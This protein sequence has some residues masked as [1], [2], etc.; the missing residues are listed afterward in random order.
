MKQTK[1]ELAWWLVA[2][3]AL[4]GGAARAQITPL[5][6][7]A[8][9]VVPQQPHT[10]IDATVDTIADSNIARTND[11][12]AQL[13]GL[14]KA[15]VRF[16]PSL[17]TDLYRAFGQ[18]YVSL[19]ASGGYDVNVRNS[20]LNS[21]RIAAMVGAGSQ[22]GPCATSGYAGYNR[23]QSDL[24]D[25]IVL[26]QGGRESVRNT[27]TLYWVSGTIACGATYGLRPLAIGGYA[28]GRNS[29]LSRIGGDYRATTY[30][31][32]LEYLHPAIGRVRLYYAERD[33]D[34]FRRDGVAYQG[35]P[36]LVSRA[37][38]LSFER[39]IGAALGGHVALTYADVRAR[40]PNPA[41]SFN[42][43]L[44]EAG[45]TLKA[46]RRIKV[47]FDTGRSVD[48]SQGFNV[49]YI[50]RENYGAGVTYALSERSSFLIQWLHNNLRYH[51]SDTATVVPVYRR[52]SDGFDG[53][54]KIAASRRLSFSVYAG[55][56]KTSSENSMYNFDSVHG[57]LTATVRLK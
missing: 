34:F 47:T 39:D 17:K 28:E 35:S 24:V 21:E 42:G 14:E 56:L 11:Q 2:T 40:G 53:T 10:N 43:L 38:T 4:D 18:T 30:G 25:L 16:T 29:S 9:T 3:L 12:S 50:S 37:G 52:T 7:T 41:S 31:G 5:A 23:Q 6:N 55:Y 22:L 32:G 45:L 26:T 20:T 15:D 44:W 8:D 13:R 33:I 46:S 49:D 51:Y 19:T 54:F 48:P 27:Q 57:G 1:R 36:R